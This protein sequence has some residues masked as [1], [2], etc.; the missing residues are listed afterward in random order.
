MKLFVPLVPKFG[1]GVCGAAPAGYGVGRGF[2]KDC[3]L[4]VLSSGV[5]VHEP[6]S[7]LPGA[8]AVGG[9]NGG[10]C[11]TGLPWLDTG[12][13]SPGLFPGGVS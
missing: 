4:L 5:S 1:A 8:A 2:G 11:G 9:V 3:G 6:A 12:A 13:V 7:K 10:C